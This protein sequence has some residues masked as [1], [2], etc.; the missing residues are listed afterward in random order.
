MD[1]LALLA[2]L[3]AIV[4]FA[5]AMSV[6]ARSQAPFWVPLGLLL[7]TVAWILQLVGLTHRLHPH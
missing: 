3:A 2:A 4:C 1:V 7:L 6:R 5:L